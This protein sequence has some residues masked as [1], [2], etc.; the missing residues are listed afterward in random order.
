[1]RGFRFEAALGA[2]AGNIHVAGQEDVR[3]PRNVGTE[4][5][6]GSGY[7]R[8]GRIH[9]LVLFVAAKEEVLLVMSVWMS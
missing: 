4:G 3:V 2:G 7:V 6:L 5:E 9:A 1:M 8:E